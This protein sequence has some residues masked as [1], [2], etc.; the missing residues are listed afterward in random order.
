MRKNKRFSFKVAG[1]PIGSQIEFAPKPNIMA[2][3]A[4]E[5]KVEYMGQWWSLSAL[6]AEL[7]S[8]SSPFQGPKYWRYNGKLLSDY[9]YDQY[10]PEKPKKVNES[11]KKKEISRMSN[12]MNYLNYS[13]RASQQQ[14]SDQFTNYILSASDIT[15]SF[16][17]N[18]VMRWGKCLTSLNTIYNFNADPRAIAA[19]KQ[20]KTVLILT[21]FPAVEDSWSRLFSG[22]VEQQERFKDWN[23]ISLRNK[24]QYVPGTVNVYFSS[25]QEIY[26]GSPEKKALFYEHNYDMI[27]LDEYHYGA[28]NS[29]ARGS[30]RSFNDEIDDDLAAKVLSDDKLKYRYRLVLTGTPYTLFERSN[31]FSA[32]KGNLFRFTYFDEQR[33]R[34]ANAEQSDYKTCPILNLYSISLKQD[35]IPGLEDKIRFLLSNNRVFN[36]NSGISM[37]S[38]RGSASFWLIPTVSKAN[39]I[40]NYINRN[41]PGQY[42]II[43]LT[44]TNKNALDYVNASLSRNPDRPSIILSYNKLT[45]GVTI[46]EVDSVV[47][48]RDITTPELYMQAACRSKSQYPDKSK[49]ISYII[50]F[51]IENDFNIFSQIT[52]QEI[53][54][55][56]F[57]ELFP[58]YSVECDV[59]NNEIEI[60]EISGKTSFLDALSKVPVRELIARSVSR[61]IQCL[62]DIPDDLKSALYKI[63]GI[64]SGKENAK[65]NDRFSQQAEQ[66][67]KDPLKVIESQGKSAGRRDKLDGLTEVCPKKYS[68][69]EQQAAYERG[70]HAGYNLVVKDPKTKEE[71]EEAAS[72]TELVNKIQLLIRRFIYILIGD[73]YRENKFP[74]IKS[75]EIPQAFFNSLLGFDRD[76]FIRLYD[77]VIFDNEYINATI[78]TM[79]NKENNNTNYLGLMEDD[80]FDAV[81]MNLVTLEET[82]KNNET[83]IDALAQITENLINNDTLTQQA[84]KNEITEGREKYIYIAQPSEFL[85]GLISCFVT[86]KGY[87]LPG[88]EL[89]DKCQ[90]YITYFTN[91]V[92]GVKIGETHRKPTVRLEELN[93]YTTNT[94][95]EHLLFDIVDYIQVSEDKSDSEF[96]KYLEDKGYTRVKDDV[97]REFFEISAKDA[98]ALLKQYAGEA[99]NIDF[100]KITFEEAKSLGLTQE[101]MAWIQQHL[102]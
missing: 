1:I 64:G 9:K 35:K 77:D 26:N 29:K 100:S 34:L 102:Q 68:D 94:G 52:Q 16:C 8:S 60:N 51:N 20:I 30:M 76:L 85:K 41:Y 44:R 58:V 13:L 15:P 86:L 67:A 70:Y 39:E 59:A 95:T 42:N 40:E 84:E 50:S 82:T 98:I 22:G 92:K 88:S 96:H 27:I 24:H 37:F 3:V 18:A 12:S 65:T 79:K 83:A 61:R 71:K 10:L 66:N 17:F 69:P 57:L 55:E 74:D 53:N 45:L 6:T 2:R 56:E 38:H 31:E 81:D 33:D 49:K 25:F 19:N 80:E 62:D 4:S 63:S 48:L 72:T 93:G 14:A 11:C 99:A 21:F 87:L 32:E 7:F 78:L 101:Y 75:K 47:F 97:R 43:N 5:N 91:I 89:Y 90:K 46:P 28:Y 73:Y 36:P 23:F 54:E